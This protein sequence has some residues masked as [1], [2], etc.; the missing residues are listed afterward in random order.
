MPNANRSFTYQ[1]DARAARLDT[2]GRVTA[3]AQGSVVCYIV[4]F[5]AVQF[6]AAVPVSV[7]SK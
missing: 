3:P 2:L 1:T 4:L 6:L 5:K 7:S